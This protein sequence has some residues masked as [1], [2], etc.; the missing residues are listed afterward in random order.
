M[1]LSL[2]EKNALVC[3]ASGG[4][5]LAIARELA[6]NGA[7]VT[8]VSRNK[9]KLKSALEE[10]KAIN[11]NEHDFVCL[12]LSN[13][14]SV[15]NWAESEV[16]KR[17]YHIIINNSGGPAPGPVHKAKPEE[18]TAAFNQHILASHMIMQASIEAMKEA[19]YG[20]IINIIST[21]VKQP[22]PNLGVSNTIR[23]A[24]AN[25]AKTL[26]NELGPH[27]ITVNNVLPGATATERLDQIITNKSN[28]E[29]ISKEEAIQKMQS[30]VPA[31]RFA[32]PEELA[33]VVAFLASP[34]ASYMNGINIPVDGGRTSS[35]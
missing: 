8:L 9:E 6:R 7:K 1:N 24:M 35:L 19:G 10:L 26:S 21:S 11:P 23:G 2:N 27:K 14:K 20:R 22:L 28:K 29:S 32:E 16:S 25:W 13:L 30:V 17:K 15:E 3:G 4:I 18:F 12:D 33:N 34:A 5:G 31:R